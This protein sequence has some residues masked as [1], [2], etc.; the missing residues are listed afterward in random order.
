MANPD[1][2]HN[3]FVCVSKVYWRLKEHGLCDRG[4]VPQFYGTIEKI[5]PRDYHPHLKKFLNDQY[6]PNAILL[7]YIPNMEMLDPLSNVTKRRIENFISGIREIHKALIEHSDVCPR[8]M[9]VLRDDPDDRVIWLDFDRAQTFDQDTLTE[10]Q[11]EWMEFEERCVIEMGSD[12]VSFQYLLSSVAN[13][14]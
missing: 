11:K 8:N 14:V 3:I 1:R 13:S 2:E 6:P 9:M 4:I 7:E 12:M 10:K 5:D